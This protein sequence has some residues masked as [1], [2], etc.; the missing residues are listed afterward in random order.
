MMI[1]MK[2]KEAALARRGRKWKG[3]EAKKPWK[4]RS[5]G[6]TREDEAND[7]C[8]GSDRRGGTIELHPVEGMH[9]RWRPWRRKEG[10]EREGAREEKEDRPLWGGVGCLEVEMKWLENGVQS[11]GRKELGRP[12]S[13]LTP[14]IQRATCAWE[15]HPYSG[16]FLSFALCH[17]N[18]PAIILL[19]RCWNQVH[20]SGL[21]ECG[22]YM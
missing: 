19:K 17:T 6:G 7:S 3:R 8:I 15:N 16:P 2:L 18:P 10:A 4:A 11:R 14:G 20:G 5:W 22:L 1:A 9:G 12:L 21:H 13:F